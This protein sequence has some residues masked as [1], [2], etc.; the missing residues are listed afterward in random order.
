MNVATLNNFMLKTIPIKCAGC[1]GNLDITPEMENFSCGYCGTAQVVQRSGGTISL[2]VV[3]EA[4]KRVQ[5]G[6]DKTAAEL[7]IKRLN[8][9]LASLENQI[10]ANAAAMKAKS[11]Q[12]GTIFL[13]TWIFSFIISSVIGFAVGIYTSAVTVFLILASTGA[14]GY[15]YFQ[16]IAKIKDIFSENE[17]KLR[18]KGKNINTKIVK[19]KQLVD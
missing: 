16:E 8:G 2:K 7:A 10:I 4:I 17:S 19:N 14:I 9:E 1:G 18:A 12:I 15:F 3:G 5:V 6:T 13:F 11:D